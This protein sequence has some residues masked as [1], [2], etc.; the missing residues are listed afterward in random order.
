L[1]AGIRHFPAHQQ[2]GDYDRLLAVSMQ[3]FVA[4]VRRDGNTVLIK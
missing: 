3:S 4:N 1:S 2:A